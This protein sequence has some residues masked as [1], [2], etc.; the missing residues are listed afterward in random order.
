MVKVTP[1]LAVPQ[2]GSCASSG[3][4]GRLWAARHSQEEAGSKPA[5]VAAFDL[6]GLAGGG[7]ADRFGRRR[8]YLVSLSLFAL[9]YCLSPFAPSFAVRH[10]GLEP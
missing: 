6:S 10:T 4:A 7:I 1:P 9:L 5:D 3:R 2:L 8:T